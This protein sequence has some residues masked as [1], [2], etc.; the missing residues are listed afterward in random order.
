[1]RVNVRQAKKEDIISMNKLFCKYV[2]DERFKRLPYL[3]LRLIREYIASP[4]C[5]C[6]VAEIDKNVVGMIMAEQCAHYGEIIRNLNKKV[7]NKERSLKLCLA[8]KGDKWVWGLIWNKIAHK[9]KEKKNKYKRISH[10]LDPV[11]SNKDWF[12]I[13]LAVL[14]KY[15]GQGIAMA[16]MEQRDQVLKEKNARCLFDEIK[17]DN[18]TSIALHQFFDFKL[19]GKKENMLLVGKRIC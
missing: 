4:N 9:K 13:N 15:E 19:I 8:L 18:K 1:M 10:E 12:G 11:M 6:L 14:P 17:Q 16:L 3:S 5:L 2:E 7:R